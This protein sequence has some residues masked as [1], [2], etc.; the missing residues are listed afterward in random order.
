MQT[1]NP[2]GQKSP[3]SSAYCSDAS[4]ICRASLR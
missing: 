2:V 1:T 3:F 4:R